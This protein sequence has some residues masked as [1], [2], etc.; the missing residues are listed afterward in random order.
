M[1]YART[2]RI[3]AAG[4]DWSAGWT[5]WVD[6]D[7]DSVNDGGEETMRQ[8][9]AQTDNFRVRAVDSGGTAASELAF[10][11][12]GNLSAPT[13]RTEFGICRPDNDLAK[14]RGV[15]VE[16]NGRAQ[17]QKNISSGWTVNCS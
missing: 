6:L 14:S 4:G 3:A 15:R 8:Q 16:L 12:T 13:S 9:P 17:A 11:I 5:V 10:G 2:V 7:S 1:R